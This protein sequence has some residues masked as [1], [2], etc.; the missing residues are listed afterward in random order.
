[1]KRFLSYSQNEYLSYNPKSFLILKNWLHVFNSTNNLT[2]AQYLNEAYSIH[3]LLK[4][5][6]ELNSFEDNW[7]RVIKNSRSIE[8][9]Q[10][11]K[12]LWFDGF[13]TLK[14]IHFLRDNDFP[15]INMFDAID[16]MLKLMN[17]ET[18]IKRN[19]S[20]PSLEIQMKYLE[21]LKKYS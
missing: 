15:Q 11:Q 21:H 1:M 13:K 4:S 8:Q 3:P 2:S 17:C 10:K 18:V 14:L 7:N 20:I 12:I 6:L 16:E 9:I 5:F 19:E